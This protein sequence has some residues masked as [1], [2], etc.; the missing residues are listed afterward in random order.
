LR[1][2]VREAPRSHSLKT[3]V[4]VRRAVP[5]DAASIA[6][7]HVRT[8]QLA[9]RGLMADEVLDGLSVAQREQQWRGDLREANPA[10]YVAVEAETVVGFCAVA[11]PSRDGDADDGVAEI[12]AIYV[13]PSAWR[14]GVGRALMNAALADLRAEQWRWVTLWVLADNQ[15]A[16][17]FYAGFGFEPDGAEMTHERSGQ[18][19]VRLRGRVRL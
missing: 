8:W 9:Y 19:E 10:V 11:A 3:V 6:A 12:G 18:K 2:Y 16:R 1:Y 5:D 7:V 13:L 17:D 14:S 4:K 15:R